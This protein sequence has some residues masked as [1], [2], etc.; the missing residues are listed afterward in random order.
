M[1]GI[2]ASGD[3]GDLLCVP[4]RADKRPTPNSGL[5]ASGRIGARSFGVAAG[6]AGLANRA[7]IWSSEG[8]AC[9]EALRAWLLC[10]TGGARFGR[11][12]RPPFRM[13]MVLARAL[14][15][16]SSTRTTRAL[17]SSDFSVGKATGCV[18]A[19]GADDFL[20]SAFASLS[21][22]A[23]GDCRPGDGREKWNMA[24]DSGGVT[25]DSVA[26][27]DGGWPI[28]ERKRALRS[29]KARVSRRTHS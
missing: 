13:L 1:T 25:G 27:G 9:A 18:P 3:E 15:S 12:V 6:P 2:V 23:M 26:E 28:F 22:T 17:L 8:S 4:R 16:T 19:V 21:K 10:G 5:F 20:S 11:G 29:T 14:K 7:V 24:G